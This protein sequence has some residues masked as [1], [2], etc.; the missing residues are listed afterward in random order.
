MAILRFND[1]GIKAISACVPKKIV[2][3]YDLTYM[4]SEESIE[5]LVKSTGIRERRIADD[6][7]CSSDLCCKINRR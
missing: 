1:I 2:S 7:V 4:M 5:K 3:N 6:D